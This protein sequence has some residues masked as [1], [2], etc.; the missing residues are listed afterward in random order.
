MLVG[1]VME[2]AVFLFEVP[3]GIVADIHSRRLSIVIGQAVMGFAIIIVGSFAVT[4]AILAAWALWGIGYTFT[5]GAQDAWLADE[6]GEER[7][8]GIYLRGAQ[9]SRVFALLGIGASVGLALVDLRLPI[10]LG[11]PPGTATV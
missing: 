4:W 8:A 3:T 1:T 10:L 6:V 5:S 2:L 9:V 7:L 11:A